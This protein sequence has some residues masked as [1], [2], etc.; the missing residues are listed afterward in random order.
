MNKKTIFAIFVLGGLIAV[1]LLIAGIKKLQFQAMADAGAEMRP[2]PTSVS[3]SIVERQLWGEKLQAIGSIE[4]VQGVRLD[5]EVPG[6]VSA[7]NFKNGQEVNQGDMLVQ[8]DIAPEAA[9]L[10]SDKANAQLAKIEL[11]RA[12]RLRDTNSVAQSE[13]D[14]AQAN[15]EIALAQVKNIEAII[16]QK[17]IRAP[18]TGRVGIRQINLGQYLSSGTPIVTLQSYN[19]V[20]VNFTLP[21]Q[22]IGRVDTGMLIDLKSDA[23]PEKTF[24]GSV[25]AISPQI[26]S[27]TRTIEM[28]GTL[29]NA[30]GYLRPGLFVNV[31]VTLSE[32]N[33]VIV[34]PSTAII[35]APYGNSI[36]K[37]NKQTDETTGKMITTVKQSFIRIG[38]RKGDF[39]SVLEGLEADDEVVSAGAFKLRNEMPVSIQND[40]A[41]SPELA[42]TPNNS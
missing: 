37:I 6:V 28:Q 3:T 30:D 36:F 21:Q 27:A 17:T 41:P 32:S 4:P 12:Q 8:L 1:L 22:V 20:F 14:R 18:F 40:L 10:K 25:T 15:Y 16:E 13:L 2:P 24:R 39:V 33:E 31:S 7:I 29:D 35:Y 42:P 11:D 5:A 9:L 34:I 23:Y 19:R 26:N 38:K